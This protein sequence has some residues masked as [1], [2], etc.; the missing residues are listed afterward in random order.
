MMAHTGKTKAEETKTNENKDHRP[1]VRKTETKFS[2]RIEEASF[3]HG[4]GVYEAICLANALDPTRHISGVFGLKEW[5]AL[6]G[7]FPGG[8]LVAIADIGGQEKVIGVALSLRMNFD[9][10]AKPLRWYD[11]IGDLTLANHDPKGAWLY[12][13]EKAVHP[14]F[15]GLG[16]GSALYE[17]QFAL[18]EKEGL[19]GIL[20]GGMLK[21]YARYKHQM[22]V[23]DYAERVVRG[24]I[25]DPTVSVQMRRGFKPCGVIENYAWDAQAEHTG[26]L[27]VWE[28]PKVLSPK[29]L[30]TNKPLSTKPRAPKPLSSNLAPKPR[31]QRPRL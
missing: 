17:A 13:V 4:R 22:S 12:G 8:Q 16:V 1:R 31:A 6:L 18:V 20:A 29:P 3:H 27:I 7:R 5:R 25:F 10:S 15:Q 24:E 11:V 19:E 28:P 14:D 9:P 23:H 21:G 30:S 2:Y 26:M